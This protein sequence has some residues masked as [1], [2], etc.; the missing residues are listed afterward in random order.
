ME[1]M[2][3]DLTTRLTDD[4]HEEFRTQKLPFRREKT[5]VF[6]NQY[7]F[8][9][10]LLVA[11]LFKGETKRRVW[12]PDGIWYGFET[13]ER[14]D[15]GR[16]IKYTPPEDVI[17][18]FVK[19]GTLIPTVEYTNRASEPSEKVIVVPYG[20]T[21]GSSTY[22]YN[23]DGKTTSDEGVWIRLS[24]KNGK[25]ERTRESKWHFISFTLSPSI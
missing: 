15:G 9:S 11:P 12:L 8:G 22:I 4:G 7:F 16:M 2:Y 18:V 14:F 19:D 1:L 25:I 5:F 21:E 20:N 10:D 24:V 6:E 23:D 3:G 17:P 13:G